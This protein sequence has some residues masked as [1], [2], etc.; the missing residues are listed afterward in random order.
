MAYITWRRLFLVMSQI[1]LSTVAQPGPQDG[2]ASRS[3]SLEHMAALRLDV[4]AKQNSDSTRPALVFR[5]RFGLGNRMLSAVSALALAL[6]TN[7]RLF[8]EW[9]Y[10]FEGLFECPFESGWRRPSA[11]Q[12]QR[13]VVLDLTASSSTFPRCRATPH[14]LGTSTVPILKHCTCASQSLTCGE[15]AASP[16][17]LFARAR[18]MCLEMISLSR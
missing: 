11:A 13:D 15:L 4:W 8:V 12:R 14:G 3:D 16:P 7:R 9:E 6:V 10:P 1:L 18:M 17:A 5:P 2:K